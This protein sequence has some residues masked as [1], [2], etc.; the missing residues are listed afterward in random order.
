MGGWGSGRHGGGV[1][2]TTVEACLALSS[3]TA[4][5]Q[6]LI[7]PDAHSTGKLA[8]SSVR[9]GE[10]VSSIGYEV[11][12]FAARAGWLRVHYTTTRTG[13]TSDY[14]IHLTSTPLPWGGV[15]WWFVCPLVVNGRHCS[16]RVGK[17]YLPPNGRY[18][19]CRHCYDLTYQSTRDCHWHER[20]SRFLGYPAGAVRLALQGQRTRR[21]SRRA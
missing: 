11:K 19:G 15:R 3:A 18:F 17:L 14:K 4:Q 20:I 8:W 13:E 6:K 10:E 7:L 12:T 1:E 2:K 21:R 16:R 5:R 9:T